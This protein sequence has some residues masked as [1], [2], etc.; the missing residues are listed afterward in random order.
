MHQNFHLLAIPTRT[1]SSFPQPE[2]L[3][4]VCAMMYKRLPKKSHL[5]L[6]A[7]RDEHNQNISIQNIPRKWRKLSGRGVIE[8]QYG[9][10]K[11]EYV[12]SFIDGTIYHP[13]SP[14]SSLFSDSFVVTQ[15]FVAHGR[16]TLSGDPITPKIKNTR[17]GVPL[18]N[19]N[20][21]ALVLPIY[22][23]FSLPMSSH[24]KLAWLQRYDAQMKAALDLL[25]LPFEKHLN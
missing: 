17:Y 7:C 21:E 24:Q 13:S 12:Q 11:R 3:D 6:T 15:D 16:H 2:Q 25:G 9:W 20:E 10:P 23:R 1:L 5:S 19:L 4:A 14:D 8:G 18:Y 22:L